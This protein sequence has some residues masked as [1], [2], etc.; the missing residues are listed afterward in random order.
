MVLNA[1]GAVHNAT[2]SNC[3][4]SLTHVFYLNGKPLGSDCFERLTGLTTAQVSR[5]TDTQ[6]A[7]DLD[8]RTRDIEARRQTAQLAHAAH[9]DHNAAIVASNAWLIDAL[10]PYAV[11]VNGHPN[12]FFASIVRELQQGTAH[13]DLPARAHAIIA[14]TLAKETASRG[15]KYQVAREQ[16]LA[17]LN[18][19]V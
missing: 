12:N 13:M 17:R 18:G 8:A 5:Y 19:D 10:T 2:C 15:R 14:D 6:G 9:E 3:G 7:I 4:A 11:F 16:L 1:L